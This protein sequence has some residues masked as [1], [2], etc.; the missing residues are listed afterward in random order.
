MP[1][2][3]ELVRQLRLEKDWSLA[4][5]SARVGLTP[6]GLQ[7]KETGR[8]A[9]RPPERKKFAE[10]FGMSIDRFDAMW[11]A[12]RI[13]RVVGDPVDRG[14]PVVN[15]APAG[16]ILNYD[17]CFSD[18][19]QGFEYL[20]R[21]NVVDEF[22]FAVIAVGESMLPAVRPGDYLIFSPLNVP[23]PRASL[24]DGKVVL[25]RVGNDHKTPGCT[26]GRFGGMKDGRFIVNKDNRKFKA[27]VVPRE[28]VV[29]L[30][31]LVEHRKEWA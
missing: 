6:Q 26:I 9:I 12:S 23:K 7:S 19:G 27:V 21:G 20:A 25:I 31:V 15:R 18:S 5:L 13:D 11:R 3:G 8:T 1:A 2:I 28:D 30:A 16:V 17:E 14:I 29:Q 24:E 4:D 10:A 22:A